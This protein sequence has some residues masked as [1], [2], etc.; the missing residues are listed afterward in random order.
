[1]QG[2]PLL[3]IFV[4]TPFVGALLVYICNRI[5]GGGKGVALLSATT[6]VG[7]VALLLQDFSLSSGSAQFSEQI[8]W[9]RSLG[10]HY[11][12]GM[13]GVALI[14]AATIAVL[15]LLVMFWSKAGDPRLYAHLLLAQGSMF[16]V[17]AAQDLVLFYLFWEFMLIPVFLLISLYG[18]TEGAASDRV[19]AAFKFFVYTFV[20]AVLMLAAIL[21]LS[22]ISYRELGV[23]SFLIADLLRLHLS[24]ESQIMLAFGFLIAFLIKVPAFPFHTWFRSAQC[25]G[26]I[27]GALLFTVF[28]FQMGLYGL[29]QIVFPLCP[30]AWSVLAPLLGILGV[31]SIVYGAFLAYREENL[32]AIVAYSSI[33]HL[34]LCV[35]GVASFELLGMV[36]AVFHAV[37]HAVSALGILTLIGF[38]ER[39][40]AIRDIEE[41]HGL[42]SAMPVLAV[43]F[44]VTLLGYIALPLTNGFVGELLVLTGSFSR[45]PVLAMVAT[46]GA[47]LVAVYMLAAYK[48][49]FLGGA[50][51]RCSA[52]AD[53]GFQEWCV[54]IPVLA[55]TF[56]M[57]LF[58][59]TFTS[60]IT[61]SARYLAEIVRSR[62]VS[63]E[64]DQVGGTKLVVAPDSVVLSRP[65]DLL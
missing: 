1:M 60:V 39:R 25:S 33:S 50:V 58:P 17:L 23:R 24:P 16:G 13:N 10:V 37:A 14:L 64:D 36:G 47:I 12:L 6:S 21:Y 44:F 49:L 57:G 41:E 53:I 61:P 4:W 15:M 51:E 8:V 28:L 30:G 52:R 11:A 55:L 40:H 56:L 20:G 32:R 9:I 22:V 35:L 5:L 45:F 2:I 7:L 43:T 18:D 3:S 34:G 19:S 31:I 48:K 65:V 29:I 62:R 27:E 26:P 63:F 42:A 38:L 59:N 46:V 54:L